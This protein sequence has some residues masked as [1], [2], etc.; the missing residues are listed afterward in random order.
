MARIDINGDG[1]ADFSVNI[2]QIIA[3][4][5]LIVSIAGSYYNLKQKIEKNEIAIQ[6]AMEMPKQEV[7]VKDVEA[8]KREIDLK[9]E[10]VAIQAKENMQEIKAF[11][12]EVRNN[13]KR[14]R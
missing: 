8:M 7:G 5:T 9:I 2:T 11:E 3:L 12:I 6:R 1:K 4:G 10:K 13:Y 14:N